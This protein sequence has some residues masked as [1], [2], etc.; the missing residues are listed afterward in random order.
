[1]SYLP[2]NRRCFHTA[3]ATWCALLLQEFS[4]TVESHAIQRFVCIRS[5]KMQHCSSPI[6]FVSSVLSAP[7]Q[8]M[9]KCNTAHG[10]KEC[11]SG[12]KYRSAEWTLLVYQVNTAK[13]SNES[14][15][16]RIKPSDG[17]ADPVALMSGA[18]E[19]VALVFVDDKL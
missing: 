18:D 11:A 17:A 19:V 14:A 15:K 13:K 10:N 2:P 1:M 6:R 5:L 12:E 8:R 7:L 4:W 3:L 16:M 9:G